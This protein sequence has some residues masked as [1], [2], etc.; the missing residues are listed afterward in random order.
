VDATL[1]GGC[2][3]LSGVT[4]ATTAIA[5]ATEVAA[6]ALKVAGQDIGAHCLVNEKVKERVSAVDRQT[7]A[8]G[9]QLRIPSNWNGRYFYRGN[10][11]PDGSFSRVTGTAGSGGALSN[12]LHRGFAG[13][14]SDAGHSS[15]Q[16]P[17]FGMDPQ[18][19]IDYGDGAVA[20]LTPMAKAL[21]AAAYGNG[22][23]R[24]FI[25]GSSNGGRHAMMAAARF[26][27]EYDGCAC[28]LARLNISRDIN[29]CRFDGRRFGQAMIVRGPLE[30]LTPVPMTVLVAAF[31]LTPLLPAA[32]A[33]GKEVLH[34]VAVVVFGGRVSATQLDTLLTPLLFGLFGRKATEKLLAKKR[35]PPQRPRRVRPT[36]DRCRDINAVGAQVQDASA[37]AAH[38]DASP[39]RGSKLWN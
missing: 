27:N 37:H 18:A 7:Y 35:T 14:S 9:F 11:G 16:N 28:K 8:M 26:A 32:D 36:D 30:W 23:D 2:A 39:I 20:K 13:I 19:R 15:A 6:G 5:S 24:S 1:V 21:I 38:H 12:A 29:L 33:P 31:A 22:P 3:A 25:G 10:G 4:C 17:L 34:P